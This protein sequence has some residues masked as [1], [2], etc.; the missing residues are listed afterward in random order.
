VISV[1]HRD[2]NCHGCALR[3]IQGRPKASS[4]SDV[5]KSTTLHDQNQCNL[6][7]VFIHLSTRKDITSMKRVKNLGTA[8]KAIRLIISAIIVILFVMDLIGGPLAAGLLA[9]SAV[10]ALTAA[11]GLCPLYK[12]LGIDSRKRASE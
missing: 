11:V 7:I 6:V 5:I 12:V 9:L 3:V 2:D 8:D 10:L 1:N 4:P